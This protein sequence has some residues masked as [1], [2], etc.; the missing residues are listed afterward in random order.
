MGLTNDESGIGLRQATSTFTVLNNTCLA[1]TTCATASKYRTID[2]SC[3][4]LKIPNL[5]KS[6]TVYRRL[7]KPAYA[8][9][10]YLNLNY[11]N[12]IDLLFTTF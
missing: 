4:N 6:D 8:D 10:R 1:P 7:S 3:N 9:G 5:G 11:Y 12:S 2:G